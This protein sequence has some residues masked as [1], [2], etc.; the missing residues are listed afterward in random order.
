MN[1]N[2][3][4]GAVYLPSHPLNLLRDN[5]L[6]LAKKSGWSSPSIVE[7]VALIHSEASEALESFRNKEPIYWIRE[8]DGKP[9]GVAAEYADIIIRVMHYCG[10]L[11]IDI[12]KVVGEKLVYNQTRGY[13]HGGKTI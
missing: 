3:Y 1:I 9:E 12:E 6:E 8:T 4:K 5:C 11:G 13:R 7:Q 2:I 10:V